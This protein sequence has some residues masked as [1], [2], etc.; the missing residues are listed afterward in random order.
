MNKQ[1]FIDFIELARRVMK[2]VDDECLPADYGNIG[3]IYYLSGDVRFL[4]VEVLN[5]ESDSPLIRIDC[6]HIQEDDFEDKLKFDFEKSK[7]V[8]EKLASRAKKENKKDL[9]KCIIESEIEEC[10]ERIKELKKQ[11]KKQ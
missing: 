6:E 1:L 5:I 10:I 4:M 8:F 3:H 9:K 2:F 7:I 11:L